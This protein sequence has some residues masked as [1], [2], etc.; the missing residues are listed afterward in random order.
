MFILYLMSYG[1][2]MNKQRGRRRITTKI[3]KY[4]RDKSWSKGQKE[5]MVIDRHWGFVN[6][7]EPEMQRQ[8]VHLG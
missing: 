4:I 3:K 2:S 6:G 1:K 7:K 5:E 8:G